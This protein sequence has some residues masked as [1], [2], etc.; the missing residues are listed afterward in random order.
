MLQPIISVVAKRAFD[1]IGI[2]HA[3]DDPRFIGDGMTS[4]GLREYDVP[5]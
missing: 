5:R 3:D 2:S 1:G 4:G